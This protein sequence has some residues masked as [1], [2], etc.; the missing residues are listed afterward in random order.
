M[1]I[2]W[3]ILEASFLIEDSFILRI[4]NSSSRSSSYPNSAFVSYWWRIRWLHGYD[5][6]FSILEFSFLYN[7]RGRRQRITVSLDISQCSEKFV[8]NG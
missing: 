4:R 2:K 6:Y 1:N 8:G 7:Q 5:R 3:Y